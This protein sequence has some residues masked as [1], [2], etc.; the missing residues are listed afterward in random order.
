MA[1]MMKLAI[2]ITGASGII[3]QV[4][5]M[6]ELMVGFCANELTLG[7]ILANWLICEAA[8]VFSAGKV[9][10]SVKNKIRVF[11]LLDGFFAIVLPFSLFLARV[12]KTFMG[13]PFAQALGLYP[14]FWVSLVVILPVAFS[15]GA[16]FSAAARL[17]SE[18]GREESQALGRTYYWETIGTIFG[19]AA[20][21]FLIVRYL[22]VFQTVLWVSLINLLVV[23]CF[24]KFILS[25]S[26]KSVAA[27][28]LLVCITLFALVKAAD[29][30]QFSIQRQWR[31]L[32]LINSRNSIY[33]NI[34]VTENERQK[35]FFYNGSP[36]ITAPYPD[37][38]FIEE[39]GNFPLLF[40]ADPRKVLIIGAGAGGLINEILKHPVERIDYAE[41]DPLLIKMLKLYPSGLT[42]R[43][44][45][46]NRV[47]LI[48]TDG[49]LFLHKTKNRYDVILIGLPQPSD[50]AT[51]RLFSEEFF[52]LAKGRLNKNGIISF[53]LPG[54]LTYISEEMRD[55]NACILNSLKAGFS[56]TRIIPGDYNIIL[57]SNGQGVFK[58]TAEEF[59]RKLVALGV[60]TSLLN[61]AYLKYRFGAVWLEWF[62]RSL[63]GATKQPNR[64]LQPFA[65]FQ[66]LIFWNKEFSFSLAKA[67][68]AVQGLNLKL[69]FLVVA[70]IT[71]LFLPV[72]MRRPRFSLAYCIATSGFFGML[73]NLLLIFSF[74]VFYGYLYYML[75]LLIAVFMAGVA[76]GSI[77][78]TQRLHRF[79]SL[80]RALLR[81]E[82]L[83]CL[84]TF[85]FA[86]ALT[87]FDNWFNSCWFFMPL[88]FIPGFLVGAEFPLASR[89]YLG[90]KEEIG[91]AAGVLYAADLLGG[92]V[93]GILGGIVFLPILGFFNTCI[94]II[95]FK[96]S[97][98][99]LLGLNSSK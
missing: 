70:V 34:A 97:S 60:K 89:A 73:L 41:L 57:A 9:I 47:N 92:W 63:S 84:F 2:F 30:E 33:G 37:M 64:D 88:F 99:L 50:L 74:Q 25:R 36:V 67:L 16:L 65:V 77:L 11:L 18:S 82:I 62:N 91:W 81:I 95:L 55:L 48:N 6:R 5:L 14:V 15:H 40:H 1:R 27:T 45:S 26:V 85:F 19:G 20:F 13:I 23:L 79:S 66:V 29:L 98:I 42:E 51:N 31:G 44:L 78:L 86:V 35:T 76:A 52:V 22:P 7:I 69:I 32:G 21:T 49:R 83:A 96:L 58:T 90:S 61:P 43:E 46:D 93:A 8:G 3:A 54:S 17:Y 4:V 59:S 72:S 87:R 68:E 71:V 94:V 39:F 75:G 80:V 10:D 12:F 28:G 53:C 56:N 24:A 38:T